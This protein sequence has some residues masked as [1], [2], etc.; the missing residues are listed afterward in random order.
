MLLVVS[1]NG[2]ACMSADSKHNTTWGGGGDKL[3]NPSLPQASQCHAELKQF[4]DIQNFTFWL[5][6]WGWG[7][8]LMCHIILYMKRCPHTEEY[9]KQRP[10]PIQRQHE[11]SKHLGKHRL[12][13]AEGY[14][15]D[16]LADLNNN[17]WKHR[18]K[19]R[20]KVCWERIQYSPPINV[21][22]VEPWD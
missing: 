19:V 10:V 18:R 6:C 8:F 16:T 17:Q 5:T 1:W 21:I 15:G 13:Q 3:S 14:W 4:S 12:L 9:Y 7:S 11:A 20:W 2:K 22:A